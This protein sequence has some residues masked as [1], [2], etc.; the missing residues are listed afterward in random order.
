VNTDHQPRGIVRVMLVDDHDVV[1]QGLRRILEGDPYL[2]IVGEAKNGMEAVKQ[3][4]SL[5][6]DVIVMDLHMPHMDGIEATKAIKNQL[7]GV[8]V[9][10]LT[11]YA[12]DVLPDGIEAGIGGFMLKDGDSAQI[13]QAIHQIHE[14]HNPISPAL[15]KKLLTEYYQLRR[16]HTLMLTPR[17]KEIL[18]LVCEGISVDS[19]SHRL[20][21]SVSTQKREVREIYN[22]LGVNNRAHACSIAIRNGVLKPS[23]KS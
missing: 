8:A 4:G 12:D 11:M 16:R 3:V 15:N 14:G 21:I 22:K 17:Q 2:K 1:R 13:G 5:V 19:I 9:L 20:C 7:P 23:L 10:A 18:R 6:P